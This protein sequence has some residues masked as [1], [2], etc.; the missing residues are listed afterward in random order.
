[1]DGDDDFKQGDLIFLGS[2]SATHPGGNNAVMLTCRWI[3]YILGHLPHV[4][5]S[6]SCVHSSTVLA[7]SKS[8][9]LSSA[10]RCCDLNS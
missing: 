6:F 8:T 1:M 2:D 4:Q 3:R 10:T 9:L 7:E 5:G